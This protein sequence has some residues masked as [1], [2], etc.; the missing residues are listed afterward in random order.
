MPDE[1]V[2]SYI[3][4]HTLTVKTNICD[5][6]LLSPIAFLHVSVQGVPSTPVESY[7]EDVQIHEPIV[8]VSYRSKMMR[9][10]IAHDMIGDVAGEPLLQTISHFYIYT[11]VCNIP[12]SYLWFKGIFNN[13]TTLRA[14]TIIL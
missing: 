12:L 9:S 3:N 14:I 10:Y 8:F 5:V 4:Y 7:R 2:I 6:M 1:P 13:K 11:I